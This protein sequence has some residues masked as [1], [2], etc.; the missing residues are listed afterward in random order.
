MADNKSS[1]VQ[2]AQSVLD[3]ATQS[4]KISGS[5]TTNIPSGLATEAKQDDQLDEL[6]SIDNKLDSLSV[7][8]QGDAANALRVQ[9]ANES[10]TALENINITVT[11][12]ALEIT[13]D[14]GNPISI[15][16][17]D[18]DIRN[19]TFAT[20]TVNV[21]G[22]SITVSGS[23]TTSATDFDIR[24]LSFA[25]DSIDV[26]GSEVSVTGSVAVSATDLDIRN[27]SFISDKVDVSGSAVSVTGSVSVSAT[28][29]DIRNLTS[30]D[31][32][33]VTGGINQTADVKVSLDGEQVF[34]SNF[35]VNQTVSGTVTANLGTIA[36]VATE[37]TL[38]TINTKIP[39]LGQS[40]K[41]GSVPVT[42]ASDQ[43]ALPVSLS[44]TGGS[45]PVTAFDLDIRP[46]VS[47]DVVTVTGGA[48]Q[49][50]DVKVTLDGEQVSISSGTVGISTVPAPLNVI[51]Y[52]NA[53]NALRVHLSDDSLS[54]LENISVT[55]SNSEIEIKNDINNPIPISASSLPLPSGA[56]T[57][58]QQD[59]II[60]HVDGIENSLNLAN[61]TLDTIEDKLNNIDFTTQSRLNTLGQKDKA[62]SMP[63]VLASDQD[64]LSVTGTIG[65]APG[66][67]ISNITGTVSLPTGASTEA[68]Q[69]IIIG[70][71]DEVEST[72]TASNTILSDIRTSAQLIDDTITNSCVNIAGKTSSNI[73]YPIR[74]DDNGAVRIWDGNNSIT[75]DGTVT[76]NLGTIAG[77]AT[78]TT[79][80]AINSYQFNIDQ[81]ISSIND[82]SNDIKNYT[83]LISQW[84]Y[85]TPSS[86]KTLLVSGRAYGIPPGPVSSGDVIP[87]W[88]T[89]DGAVNIADGGGSLTVDGAV[90]ANLGTIGGVATESTLNDV[91]T[92]L[93]G[94]LSVNFTNS[95]IAVTNAFITEA[96]ATAAN[97]LLQTVELQNIKQNTA[98][99]NYLNRA[100]LVYSVTPVFTI[101]WVEL[102]SSVGLTDVKEIEIFDSS[103]ETL[104]LGVG[105]NGSE[106]SKIYVFPGGNGRIPL[107]IDAG[108]R[109]AVKSVSGNAIS[110]EII[111]NLYG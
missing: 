102:L 22:S 109:L 74:I 48:G 7:T 106:I 31:V 5:V 60:G 92:A 87:L 11:N 65:L 96:V 28:D 84:I 2:I 80:S 57:S 98:R 29:L 15:S 51:G 88:T 52:G 4:I 73:S 46:L 97:Q 6:V 103:G 16:A 111:I 34:I 40:T 89:L 105:A 13:N 42:I 10:L 39:S 62:G 67:S 43:E 99:L 110:G 38:N 32:I 33:T 91:K 26:S 44:Y 9:L 20:D 17:N 101:S 63:V 66:S 49:T 94:T 83:Q 35:P 53:T 81:N 93:N 19:L 75:V 69:D 23:V 100:R 77:V 47:S 8:G 85:T 25:T 72:L 86:D 61:I 78:E 18:L 41:S 27:L 108:E 12:T 68:K 64:A 21:S 79:L 45:I 36:G 70:Y 107:Q 90:T 56:A 1:L 55:V 14:A 37:S 104:Q 3:E 59:T 76:A 54:A 50:F 24:D 95:S 30:N 82:N 58:S 71:I